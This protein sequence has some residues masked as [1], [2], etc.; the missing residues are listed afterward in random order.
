[1]HKRS[2]PLI[3]L[4]LFTSAERAAEI[5]GDLLEQRRVNGMLWFVAHVILTAF[6][7]FRQTLIQ[8]P[9]L[10]LLP[11]YAVYELVVKLHLWA[12]Q[13]TLIYLRYDLDY[14]SEP[15]LIV[16]RAI[17]IVAGLCAWIHAREVPAKNRRP[18]SNCRHD[19]TND[20]RASS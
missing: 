20:T 1:M 5:E 14:S 9:L 6:A 17:W 15:L 3:F 12:I 2:V 7:L 10:V 8:Q 18:H 13:P 4:A 19:F 11:G 16:A